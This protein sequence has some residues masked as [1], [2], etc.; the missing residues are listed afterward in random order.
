MKYY[1][2]FFLT[3]LLCSCGKSVEFPVNITLVEL[4]N[5]GVFDEGEEIVVP[6][7]FIYK[8]EKKYRGISLKNLLASK[9]PLHK[10]DHDNIRLLFICDDNYIVSMPLDKALSKSAF[11]A[12]KDLDA[13]QGENWINFMKDG[14]P[15]SPAPFFMVWKDAPVDDNSYVW[16]YQLNTIQLNE[17]EK[18][19]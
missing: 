11:I 15:T 3:F 8:T 5:E 16:P 12:Y 1:F 19:K 10:L 18:S 17:I 7:D 14:K 13:P 9:V 2:F 4:Q 6:R